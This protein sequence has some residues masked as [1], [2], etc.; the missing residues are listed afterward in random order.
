MTNC[1]PVVADPTHLPELPQ[2]VMPQRSEILAA[3]RVANP[4]RFTTQEIMPKIL[5]L[6][7]HAWINKPNDEIGKETAA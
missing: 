3:A 6:P 1:R 7:Q 4:E 5:N 2:E